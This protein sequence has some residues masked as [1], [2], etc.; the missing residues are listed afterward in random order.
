MTGMVAQVVEGLPRKHEVLNS[1]P[2]TATKKKKKGRKER[3]QMWQAVKMVT[4][5]K[6]AF[7]CIILLAFL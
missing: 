3:K 5:E 2:S 6:N 1:N 4:L 7:Y